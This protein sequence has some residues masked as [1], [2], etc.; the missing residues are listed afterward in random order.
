[1]NEKGFSPTKNRFEIEK[2][3]K[4]KMYLAIEKK[5]GIKVIWKEVEIEDESNGI[6]S[7]MLKEIAMLKQ[8]S[9]HKNIAE[10]KEVQS[11]NKYINLIFEY[12]EIDLFTHLARM[13]NQEKKMESIKVKKK[14]KNSHT[15]YLTTFIYF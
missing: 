6:P 13:Q 10:L 9:K 3:I 8:I 12:Y 15:F 4:S 11:E 1:M 2:N 14:K 7:T 5:T